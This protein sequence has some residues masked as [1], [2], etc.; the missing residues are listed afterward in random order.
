LTFLNGMPT[1]SGAKTNSSW[2]LTLEPQSASRLGAVLT[3]TGSQPINVWF[4]S[5][6][7]PLDM[8]EH[9]DGLVALVLPALLRA[10]GAV[11][12]AGTLTREIVR[13][14]TDASEG[15]KDWNADRYRGLRISAD[16]IIDPPV[17]T[18]SSRA[19]FAWSGSLRSTHTLVRHFARR[20]PGAVRVARIVHVVGLQ[21]DTGLVSAEAI[22]AEVNRRAEG[23]DTLVECVLT[24]LRDVISGETEM[25]V[26]HVVAAAL[27]LT[28]RDLRLAFHA[29]G[30]PVSAQL[31]FPRPEPAFPDVFCGSRLLVRAD[32]GSTTP[33]QMVREVREHA[34]FLLD[35]ISG[36]TKRPRFA[37]PCGACS[38]CIVTSLAFAAADVPYPALPLP[39]ASD[40][41]R[42]QWSEPAIAAEATE[43]ASDWSSPRTRVHR[44]LCRRIERDRASVT[45]AE[46]RRWLAS[47]AGVGPIWPR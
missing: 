7:R 36:C 43:I 31:R 46:V 15:W 22:A 42:L 1:T 47:A 39:T 20:V 19:A 25:G 8:P 33:T 14:L 4:E 44:A 2:R 35:A 29:R 12:V 32:G 28:A 10:G 24:N 40:V 17:P 41:E 5:L 13:N 3:R 11:H 34:P 38:G 21:G 37:L 45:R 9:L 6:A 27:H 23:L 30:W 26:L 16:H 18:F